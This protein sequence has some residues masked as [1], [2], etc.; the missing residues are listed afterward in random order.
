MTI[1]QYEVFSA[2]HDSFL[3][4]KN[5]CAGFKTAVPDN[6]LQLDGIL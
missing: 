6:S 4:Q 5:N 3:S 1:G 2:R